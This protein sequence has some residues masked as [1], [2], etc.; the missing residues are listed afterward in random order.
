MTL[1]LIRSATSNKKK[2]KKNYNNM[3]MIHFQ[4]VIWM[5]ADEKCLA[6]RN[7]FVFLLPATP[8]QIQVRSLA[9]VSVPYAF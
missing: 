6:D 8:Q 2:K 4:E 3:I 7:A 1:S 5:R 9:L